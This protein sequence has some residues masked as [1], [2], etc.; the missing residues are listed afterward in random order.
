[1][2]LQVLRSEHNNRDMRGS[3]I[4][5]QLFCQ[6]Q[7]V[8]NRHH[9]IADY[10]VRHLF[11]GDSQTLYHQQPQEQHTHPAKVYAHTDGYRYYHQ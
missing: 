1:M 4:R 7:S 8:H 5:L 9:H 6:L 11:Q 3:R 10:Q 2:L